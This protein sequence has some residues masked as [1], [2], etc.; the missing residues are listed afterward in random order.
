MANRIGGP[1]SPR[2]TYKNS[3]QKHRQALREHFELT[4]PP[5]TTVG[6]INDILE[7]IGLK[8]GQVWIEDCMT[9]H[10][11]GARITIP[12]AHRDGLKPEQVGESD[13]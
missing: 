8:L 13:G 10:G 4:L 5:G 3:R 11:I 7:D 2:P 9:Q 12:E 1:G 6:W